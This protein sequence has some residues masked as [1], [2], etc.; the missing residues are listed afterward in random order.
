MSLCDVPHDVLEK[1]VPQC[2]LRDQRNLSASCKFFYNLLH[3]KLQLYKTELIHVSNYIRV[4]HNQSISHERNI[5]QHILFR[6]KSSKIKIT[7][8]RFLKLNYS[9]KID[10]DGL[11]SEKIQTNYYFSNISELIA[12]VYIRAL[13]CNIYSNVLLFSHKYHYYKFY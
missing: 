12:F 4:I 8:N 9:Y 7:L 6:E 2:C 11:L 5:V 1:I 13:S 3:L 10:Y